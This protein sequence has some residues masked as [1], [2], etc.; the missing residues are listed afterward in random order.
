MATKKKMNLVSTQKAAAEELEVPPE[1]IRLAKKMFPYVAPSKNRLDLDALAKVMESAAFEK[2]VEEAEASKYWK[3]RL[4][5]AQALIAEL[6]LK[7]IKGEVC[8]AP[9]VQQLI[10]AGDRAMMDAFRRYMENEQPPLIEGK[11]APRIRE[12]NKKWMDELAADLQASR[13]EAWRQLSR[14]IVDDDEED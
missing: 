2:A 4:N 8:P 12:A 1:H 6:K 9:L 13:A 3:Y 5:R 10:T 7:I 11:S 14:G